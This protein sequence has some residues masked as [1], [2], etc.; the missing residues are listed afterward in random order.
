MNSGNWNMTRKFRGLIAFL[1]FLSGAAIYAQ[2]IT[3]FDASTPMEKIR[4]LDGAVI[5]QSED[6]LLIQTQGSQ[7]QGKT[8]YPGFAVLGEWDLKDFNAVEIELVH[9]DSH[10]VRLPV[11]V[12]L[13]GGGEA[14][15]VG[16]KNAFI[17]AADAG[18]GTTVCLVP[19]FRKMFDT[20]GLRRTPWDGNS[21]RDTLQST[22]ITSVGVYM[23]K[24]VWDWKWGVKRIVLKKADLGKAA[25]QKTGKPKPFTHP[26]PMDYYRYFDADPKWAEMTPEEFFPFIDRYGQFKHKEWPGK[27]HSDAELQAAREAEEKDLEAHP[28]PEDRDEF[29]GWTAGPKLKATG[30]FRVEKVDG[31]WWMVDPLGHLFWSHGPV[32][33]NASSAVTPLDGRKHYF[34][35]LPE[36]DSPLAEF[37]FTNDAVLKDL[38]DVRGI[39]E[40]FDFSSANAW[41]KYGGEGWREKYAEMAHRRLRSWGMNTIAN[42]SDV[43]I[44]LQNR[45]PFC[46][47]I[48]M[49]S[50]FLEGA[51]D[52]LWWNFRD[53]FHPEFRKNIRE[54]LI[55]HRAETQSPY[56]FGFF[57]D[58]ELNWGGRTSLAEWTL[59]SS[60]SQPAKQIFIERL[61]KKYGTI[62]KLNQAW[63]GKYASWEEMLERKGMPPKGSSEDCAE[64][65]AATVREY[66]AVIKEEFTKNAP[67]TLY[68]GCR[69][70]GTPRADFLKIAAEYCDVLSFNIYRFSLNDFRLPDGIDKP[71]LVSEF[72]FGA[73]DRGMLHWTLIGVEDQ[74]ERA[75]AYFN[76]VDSALRHPNFVGVHW[77]QYS[78]QATT[79]RFDGEN[80]QNGFVDV[81]DTPYPETIGKIREIGYPMYQIRYGREK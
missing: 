40:T 39:R 72:H 13:A 44:A 58:N 73:L 34:E 27:I 19:I 15:L 68:L 60:A 23:P 57:V 38:Y 56:C 67:G 47:R 48:T 8:V 74:E 37:Y 11:R 35:E 9:R 36:M 12:R 61:R 33:I 20:K 24:P 54:Q 1:L 50:P 64:F 79:G 52:G 41:R 46:D 81:C 63:G 76:Y 66:F 45:T 53:P 25:A 71:L 51:D 59:K 6:G 69:Y 62:E 2:E 42:S 22:K 21:L 29:G 28:G 43:R 65:S 10:S 75:Q 5:E 14:N 78:E 55:E 77:H 17:A 80:F 4:S 18:K 3:V 16:E 32:R 26:T 31:K 49:K 30:R 7:S 70:C